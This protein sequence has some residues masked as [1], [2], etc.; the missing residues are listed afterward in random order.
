MTADGIVRGPDISQMT[1]SERAEALFNRIM[2]LDEAGHVDSVRFFAPMAIATYQMLDPI[3]IDQRYELGRIGIATGLTELTRAQADTILA[4]NP[5]HLLGL[6]L[7]AAA[8][9]ADGDA[10]LER[11]VEERLIGAQQSELARGLPEYQRYRSDIIDALR[12]AQLP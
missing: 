11:S 7:A 8:A 3:G 12:Q 9:R 4:S 5:R 1:P 6:A 10:A 2:R